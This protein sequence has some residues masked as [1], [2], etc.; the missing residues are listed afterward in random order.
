MRGLT[1]R[2]LVLVLLE[3]E[4]AAQHL[5]LVAGEPDAAGVL[6]QPLHAIDQ[7]SEVVVEA[8]YLA[9]RQ[10]QDGVGVLPDLR[11]RGEADRLLGIAPP[12]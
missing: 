3:H 12:R 4:Q 10:L 5:D 9:G 1:S 11:E 8:L 2:H 6:H 7:A